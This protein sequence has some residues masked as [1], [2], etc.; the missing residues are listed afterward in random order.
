MNLNV[1]LGLAA[2]AAT[3]LTASAADITGKVTL[4]GQAP[5]EKDIPLDPACGK[6]HANGMKTRLY[7]VGGAGELA[8]VFV[9][10]KDGVTGEKFEVPTTPGVLDQKGCEYVPYV[11]GLQTGQKLLVKNSDPVM[12]NVHPTP[13]PTT[14]N[15]EKNLA[16][17]PNGKDLEFVFENPESMLRFKCDVHPWMFS[18]VN[19]SKHP[20]YAVTAKDGTF[21]IK[22][23]PKGN[24]TVEAVHRK[25]GK[26]EQKVTVADAGAKADFT[27]EAGK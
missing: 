18:Y 6:L 13:D 20:F 9:Y 23:V 10:L 15:K 4:K 21:T 3:A 14:G 17:M 19:V 1:W 2:V 5:A 24:Y 8:D 25:A 12:H 26:A 11:S 7:V 22:N 27:L 16:Q